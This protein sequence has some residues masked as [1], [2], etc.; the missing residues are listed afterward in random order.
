MDDE[1]ISWGEALE[2]LES[3]H[4][5]ISRLVEKPHQILAS[6]AEREALEAIKHI[7]EIYHYNPLL[8]KQ[9]G[10]SNTDLGFLES[11]LVYYNASPPPG[12][13]ILKFRGEGKTHEQNE[14]DTG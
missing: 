11:R 10:W 9:A 1:N 13:P 2:L 6:S 7:L 12:N 3:A 8:L 4:P 5:L 14:Q